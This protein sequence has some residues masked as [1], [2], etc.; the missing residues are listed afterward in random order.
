MTAPLVSQVTPRRTV[1]YLSTDMF[2]TH[3]RR[4][5]SVDKLVPGGTPQDQDAALAD[6]IEQASTWIDS[7][8]D[9]TFVAGL[10][11]VVRRVSVRRDGQMVLY[12]RYTPVIGLVALAIGPD[13]GALV[14]MQDFYGICTEYQM[15]VSVYTGLRLTSSQGPLQ[16]GAVA[17]PLSDVWV[18]YTYMHGYPVTTLAADVAAG[19]VSMSLANVAGVVA[20]QTQLTA[21][22]GQQRFRFTASAVTPSYA[23]SSPALGTATAGTVTCPA[24]PQEIVAMADSGYPVMVSALPADLILASTLVTRAIIKGTAAGAISAAAASVPGTSAGGKGPKNAGDD[25]AAAWEIIE[26]YTAAWSA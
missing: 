6:Y 13:P 1:A 8:T 20:G 24:A 26:R 12:P 5:V 14:D 9:G 22:A 3:G 10:D 21:Y 2:K 7:R 23:G 17:A 19:A 25:F 18:R 15:G 4:G 11:T 16:F